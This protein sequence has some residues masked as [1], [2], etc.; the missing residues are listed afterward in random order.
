MKS[1]FLALM[2]SFG[3]AVGYGNQPAYAKEIQ[4]ATAAEN[5]PKF[6]SNKRGQNPLNQRQRRKRERQT[7]I[8]NKY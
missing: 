6:V 5:V 8:R 1:K 7:G 2:A 4:Q 3:A